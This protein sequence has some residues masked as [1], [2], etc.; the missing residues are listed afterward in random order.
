M[1]KKRLILASNS[2]RRIALLKSLGYQFDIMPHHIEE[3]GYDN[4]LPTTLV[5]RLA[6]LKASAVAKRVDNAIIVSADTIVLHN[7]NIFGKP[8]DTHDARRILSILSDSEHDVVSGV[9][10]IEAPLK[11]KLLRT[12]QTHI[13]MKRITEEE[14]EM[15]IGSGEPMDK[16]GAYAIQGIGRKFI[17]K[18]DGSYSNAVGLPLEILQ[19]MLSNF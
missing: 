9:C 2:P 11:K 17:E 10:V 3:R 16:A 7:K 4:D 18:I 15:Y 19:E 1:L 5:Q 14:I 12:A 13:K 6:F 8:K